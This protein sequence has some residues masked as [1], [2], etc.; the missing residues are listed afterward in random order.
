MQKLL[1]CIS[2]KGILGAY[3]IGGTKHLSQT[4]HVFNELKIIIMSNCYGVIGAF[5]LEPTQ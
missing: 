4:Y 2:S 3:V 1:N 5:L